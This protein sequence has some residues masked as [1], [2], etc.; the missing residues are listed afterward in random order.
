[1]AARKVISG[2]FAFALALA[3]AIPAFAQGAGQTAIVVTTCGTPPATYTAGQV[4]QTTQDVNGNFCTGGGGSADPTVVSPIYLTPTNDSLAITSGGTA[5][6]AIA[7]NPT[8]KGCTIQNPATATDQNIAA[9]ETIYV[10]FGGTAAAASTSFGIL[11][12]Q[13]ISCSPLGIGTI[14]SAVSVIGA[15]TAHKIVVVEYN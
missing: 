14:T 11:P 7:A 10:N 6:T 4:R 8:R 12:G 3:G 5:Q 9:A 2:L 13:A 1:M 15:T